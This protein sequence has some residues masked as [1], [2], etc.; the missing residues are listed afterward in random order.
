MLDTRALA[1]A[2]TAYRKGE[3]MI[4][5]G[6]FR[7][8]LEYLESAVEL[9][10]DEC[11]YQSAL[12]WSLHKQP[13]SDPDRAIEHLEKAVELDDTDATAL[14]RLGTVLRATGDGERSATYLAQAK[15]I[16]PDI[17]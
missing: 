15:M 4:R 3:I 8:S 2:E 12:G 13:K 6:D 16:D 1:Q 14:F 9:W 17:G 10:P 5:M 11:E 7:G